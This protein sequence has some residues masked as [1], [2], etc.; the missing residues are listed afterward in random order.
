MSEPRYTIESQTVDKWL[1]ERIIEDILDADSTPI[2]VTIT[3][4]QTGESESAVSGDYDTALEKACQKM[5]ISLE[6]L[7]QE[8]E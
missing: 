8:V 4:N 5:G 6:D 7:K 3:D 1:I 2:K